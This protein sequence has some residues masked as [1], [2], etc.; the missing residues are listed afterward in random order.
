MIRPNT[1]SAAIDPVPAGYDLARMRTLAVVGS[2]FLAATAVAQVP[3]LPARATSTTAFVPPGYRP[4]KEVVG[5]LNGDEHRDVVLILGDAR[6]RPDSILEDPLPR[7]LLVLAGE[8]AGFRLDVV[9]QHAVLNRVDG[10]AFGDPLDEL[11]LDRNVIIV[12]HYGGSA[13]RWRFIHKFRHQGG[14]YEL[15]GR[16]TT[17]Y[18]NATYCRRIKEYRPTTFI[19]E[20]LNTGRRYRYDVPETQCIKRERRTRFT[21]QRIALADFN[22]L[23]DVADR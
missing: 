1:A 4:M 23:K 18:F 13:W 3:Q 10:G 11:T 20:N 9:S 15:V 12:E 6:E 14:R 16:T 21:P 22:L 19:D 2:L 8:P 17:S 7:L 5:H